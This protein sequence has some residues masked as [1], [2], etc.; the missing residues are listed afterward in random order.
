MSQPFNRRR[1]LQSSVASSLGFAQL[2]TLANLTPA[3]DVRSV[4]SIRR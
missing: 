2:S 3:P 4:F 1:L